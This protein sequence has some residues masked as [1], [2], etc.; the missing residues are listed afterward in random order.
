MLIAGLAAL[1]SAAVAEDD[2]G[3]VIK[4]EVGVR[5]VSEDDSPDKAAEYESTE[6][7]PIGKVLLKTDGSW[8]NLL[9]YA[10]YVAKDDNRGKL[11]FD[12]KRMVRSHTSYDL[13]P[14]RLGHDPMENLEATSINGKV[15]RHTD[16]DPNAE[17]GLEYSVIDHRTELQ[18]PNLKALTLAVDYRDQKREGHMQAY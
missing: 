16:L 3:T 10:D 1:P 9:L 8:G 6:D 18:F 11:D 15:V 14:H 13:F 4:A 5:G 2:G 17:Y 12:I 7:G